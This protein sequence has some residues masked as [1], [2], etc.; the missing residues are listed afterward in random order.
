MNAF[1]RLVIPDGGFRTIVADPPWSY[2]EGFATQSRTQGKWDG[3]VTRK[4]LPYPA[5]T[6]TEIEALPVAD[7]ASKDCRLWLWTTNRYLP[8][9]FSVML[10]WGFDYRQKLVWHKADGNMGGSVAP[11][12]AEFL[13]VGV[14][15]VAKCLRASSEQGD[16]ALL[17]RQDEAA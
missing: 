6:L 12:S 2:P 10:A 3:P 15:G 16:V 11:N 13:L 14:R 9:A 4:P 17:Q 8:S 1:E 7:V 5:M